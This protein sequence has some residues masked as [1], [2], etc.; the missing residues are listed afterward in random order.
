MTVEQVLKWSFY[1]CFTEALYEK[2]QTIMCRNREIAKLR[3]Q[4]EARTAEKDMVTTKYE[5]IVKESEG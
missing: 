1:G 4:V 3:A 2:K 5:A